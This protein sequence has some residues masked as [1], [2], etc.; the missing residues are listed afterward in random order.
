MTRGGPPKMSAIRVAVRV[1]PMSSSD[2]ALSERA[3]EVLEGETADTTMREILLR[4]DPSNRWRPEGQS[5]SR[6]PVDRQF[7]YDAVFGP[8]STNDEVHAATTS[9]LLDGVLDGFNA[10]VFAYGQTGAGKTHTILG[11]PS[12]DG[13]AALALK[14]LF[15]R[16]KRDQLPVKVLV[17]MVE[18]YQERI[19]DLLL[20]GA[21][22]RDGEQ[23]MSVADMRRIRRRIT[24]G[25]DVREDP[26][27]G[28]TVAGATVFAVDSAERVIE[29]LVSGNARRTTEPTGANL[30]SSRSHAVLSVFVSSRSRF[31][32]FTLI[33]LAGNERAAATSNRG[34]RFKEGASINRSLLSL[35][36][37][38]NALVKRDKIV[39]AGGNAR[40][41]HIPFRDSK[42]TR[43]LK[44][45]LGGNCRT[46]L[47]AAV[48]P[49]ARSFAETLNTLKYANRVKQ[50]RTKV[51]RNVSEQ[52]PGAAGRAD[53]GSFSRRP[54]K[55]KSTIVERAFDQASAEEVA[56]LRSEVRRLQDL[57]AESAAT[58]SASASAAAM[59]EGGGGTLNPAGP[60]AI[61]NDTAAVAANA[62]LAKRLEA[63]VREANEAQRQEAMS[64][65]R[66]KIADVFGE[67]ERLMGRMSAVLTRRDRTLGELREA[68]KGRQ[69]GASAAVVERRQTI[70]NRAT[71]LQMAADALSRQ[72]EL[73][74]RRAGALQE[75]LAAGSLAEVQGLTP[76]L[77][78]LLTLE[79]EVESLKVRNAAL[80][81][82]SRR[83]EK[84][85]LQEQNLH[86]VI[87]SL[88]LELA[89][90]E[91]VIAQLLAPRASAMAGGNIVP[92]VD[93]LNLALGAAELQPQFNGL[94]LAGYSNSIGHVAVPPQLQPSYPYP[95]QQQQQQ[96]RS[97]RQRYVGSPRTKEKTRGGLSPTMRKSDIRRA[98]LLAPPA[99]PRSINQRKRRQRRWEPKSPQ[100]LGRRGKGGASAF[101]WGN[102]SSRFQQQQGRTSPTTRSRAS[103]PAQL[104]GGVGGAHMKIHASPRAAAHSRPRVVQPVLRRAERR[105]NP[106][107]KV[108]RLKPAKPLNDP[109]TAVDR[110]LG[111]AIAG[112][113][114]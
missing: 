58:V 62:E 39:R 106:P 92:A 55:I 109:A 73:N 25:L 36:N 83:R 80:A 15:A 82:E 98:P 63:A 53:V 99:A 91:Q 11:T 93:H 21:S 43:L 60:N 33:D 23:Q 49:A 101:N 77:R 37:C 38:I 97:P 4:E 107:S 74:R 54:T 89:K 50:L 27:R 17:S 105:A 111:L 41:V 102:G 95:Y 110:G 16:I 113:G 51:V 103:N 84:S 10:T 34:A 72:I 5:R 79:A 35:G 94:G 76:P 1:R 9:L 46:V 12:I 75:E 61:A 13:C 68:Q 3:V 59:V 57:L 56:R 112:T 24:N 32:K 48:S 52:A 88:Q 65:A 22:R 18:I 67:S 85:V 71:E 90:R 96:Q 81:G 108:H 30:T 8:E 19:H 40:S 69:V 86:A 29:L 66:A 64:T 28:P 114:W 7:A 6:R 20:S 31:S 100:R 47:I 78:E 44:D 70:S 45:A 14:Q 42:L 2:N 87:A 26:V 104:W